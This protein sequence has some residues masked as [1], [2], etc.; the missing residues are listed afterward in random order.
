MSSSLPFLWEDVTWRE[1]WGTYC[2]RNIAG[3]SIVDGGVLSNCPLEYILEDS[4]HIRKVMGEE[5]D[6]TP[7]RAICFVFD[8]K[9]PMG[10]ID[11]KIAETKEQQGIKKA[12][13]NLFEHLRMHVP[14][15]NK[16]ELL[17]STL[18]DAHD[19]GVIHTYN[20]KVVFIPSAEVT[21]T[22]FNMPQEKIDFFI[23][24][25]REATETKLASHFTN[26][27][28]PTQK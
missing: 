20:E 6:I 16:V 13:G 19:N 7:D 2:G 25:A 21:T 12:E 26:N 9:S 22:E 17:L 28:T 1:R 15:I 10:W 14:L 27:P 18:L 3:H 23:E 5:F 8:T 4:L 11:K 24:K